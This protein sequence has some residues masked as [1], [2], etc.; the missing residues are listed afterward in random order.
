M[1]I[2]LIK[3][4]VTTEIPIQACKR[5]VLEVEEFSDALLSGRT[6]ALD[7]A[8][9]VRNNRLIEKILEAAQ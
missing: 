9:T 5:Y 4:G 8:E 2:L 7:L 1:P 3:D 6:P